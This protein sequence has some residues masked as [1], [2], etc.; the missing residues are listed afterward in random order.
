V[1]LLANAGDSAGVIQ[2][3]LQ[4]AGTGLPSLMD[5]QQTVY[6][7][8]RPMEESYAPFPIHV[9]IDRNGTIQYLR[10]QYDAQAAR[11]SIDMLLDE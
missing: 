4:Q 6:E 1:V 2:T 3:F 5:Q 10:Q 9:V 8:Y 7:Q 11:Y